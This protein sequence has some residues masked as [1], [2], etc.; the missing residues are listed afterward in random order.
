MAERA[1]TLEAALDVLELQPLDFSGAGAKDPASDPAFYVEPPPRD[2]EGDGLPG[3]GPAERL[4]DRLLGQRHHTKLF[5][6]GHVGSGTSTQLNKLATD[7]ALKDAFSL[8]QLRIEA[9]LVPFLDAAQLL[10][11]IAGAIFDFGFR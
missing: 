8:V 5:L 9:G 6:S 3:P 10:F 7:E 11:L 2:D 1:K 4:R